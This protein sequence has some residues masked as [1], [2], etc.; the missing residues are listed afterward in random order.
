MLRFVP[1]V[2]FIDEKNR[3]TL[4]QCADVFDSVKN[5]AE[6]FDATHDG[7]HLQKL[8]SRMGGQQPGDAGL[9]AA[10]GTPEQQAC[11]GPFLQGYAQWGVGSNQVFLTHDFVQCSRTHSCCEW[12]RV[13]VH[14]AAYNQHMRIVVLSDVHCAGTEDPVQGKFVQW[15]DDLVCD[16]LWLLGDIFHWGWAFKG[17]TQTPYEPV[18]QAFDRLIARKVSIVFVPGNH[19][20]ALADVFAL[21]WGADVSGPGIRTVDDVKVFIA[22]GDEGDAR[23]GYRCLRWVIR[24]AGFGHLMN[25]LGPVKGTQLLQ[26][27]A[28]KV[29]SEAESVWP[30][31]QSWLCGHLARADIALMGHVHKEWEHTGDAGTAR[32]LV[33]G[34]DGALI[35]EDGQLSTS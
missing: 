3:A 24:G 28:G 27:L 8:Q 13:I 25:L 14:H 6:F 20:F 10:G 33:P 1:T 2:Y 18:F 9:S 34:I 7:G 31:I 23:F 22:H 5:L 17:E 26:V 12:L 19:D 30:Q 32:V 15:L 29:P 11:D 4:L 16:E 35:I 21:R